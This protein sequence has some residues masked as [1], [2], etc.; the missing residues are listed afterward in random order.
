MKSG[1]AQ[2]AVILAKDRSIGVGG[3]EITGRALPRWVTLASVSTSSAILM[4][5]ISGADLLRS[6]WM[7]DRRVT[8]SA[9]VAEPSLAAEVAEPL[10]GALALASSF[11]AG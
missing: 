6:M 10:L 8:V 5:S 1:R 3:A 2:G 7:S 9:F 4:S 11:F